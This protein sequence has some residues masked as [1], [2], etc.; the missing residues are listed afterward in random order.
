[1]RRI[2]L[3]ESE[4][5]K[6]VCN[7]KSAKNVAAQ[8]LLQRIR[9]HR[10]SAPARP[11]RATCRSKAAT[12]KGVHFA[13]DFL[14]ANTK[15]LLDGGPDNSPIH[16][17][18]QGRH[19]HRR[20]RHRH[21]LRRHL[22]C[23]TAASSL[24]QLEILPQPPRRARRRQSVAGVAEGLQAGLRPGR[25]RREVRR[26]P[27]RLSDDRQEVRGRRARPASKPLR[28]RAGQVGTNDKGQFIPKDVPGTEKVRPAQLVLLAMGFLGPEQPLLDDLGVERDA[29]S[30]V[31]SRARELHDEPQGR[32]RRRRLPPRP[33]PRRLGLQRR[34]RR[35]RGAIAT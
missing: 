5:I 17:R 35:R 14:T 1:M 22:A 23:A 15:A 32:L 29:R 26:R 24:V 12:C 16:A 21:R 34:P 11:S 13:M 8:M 10:C 27:A 19:R 2:K 7:A 28:D 25:S 3:M 20:R 9:R 30:N 4:G 33:E 31:Q 6:F 18:R